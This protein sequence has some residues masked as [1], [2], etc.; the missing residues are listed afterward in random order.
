[1]SAS[2]REQRVALGLER[3]EE[4]LCDWVGQGLAQLAG[5]P[6]AF[7]SAAAALVDAQAGGLANRLRSL[8]GDELGEGT[9]PARV[10]QQLAQLYLAASAYRRQDQLPP[11]ARADLR[12][13]IGWHQRRSDFGEEQ[14]QRERALVVGRALVSEEEYRL[15]RIWLALPRTRRYALV[16]EYAFGGRPFEWRLAPGS[17]REVE[18]AFYE[19]AVP[20]RVA[21]R[22]ASELP[23]EAKR[24]GSAPRF[25]GSMLDGQ[26]ERLESL[27]AAAA[28]YGRVLALNPWL[29]CLPLRLAAVVPHLVDGAVR[30]CDQRGATI[31]LD[32]RVK[33]VWELFAISGGRPLDCFGEWR[34]ASFWP[35]SVVAGGRFI[36]LE[37][38]A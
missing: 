16:V 3:F 28:A 33:A 38:G 11:G 5:R 12:R 22:Q 32:E 2:E 1:M 37:A 25:D 34:S 24:R 19:S 31:A 18:L 14:W 30:L 13:F 27:D 20:L 8:A 29:D 4:Q 10:L 36:P 21:L 23:S 15:Q 7:E 17:E 9:W 6:R 26:T 35:L